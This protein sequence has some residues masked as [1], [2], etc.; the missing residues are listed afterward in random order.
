MVESSEI[1][2]FPILEVEK[3]SVFIY[4]TSAAQSNNIFHEL[5]NHVYSSGVAS[6]ENLL[7]RVNLKYS[8]R[9]HPSS[10]DDSKSLDELESTLKK[11]PLSYQEKKKVFDEMEE[12]I[13][14]KYEAVDSELRKILL[15]SE[16]H[17]HL[18]LSAIENVGGKDLLINPV[19]L[20]IYEYYKSNKSETKNRE[21]PRK[22]K[23]AFLNLDGYEPLFVNKL[24]KESKD[25]LFLSIVR[26]ALR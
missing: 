8:T 7:E 12:A 9:K 26:E 13:M 5:M 19:I 15:S 22:R 2:R 3:P 1:N 6:D 14:K 18:F 24:C 17:S 11:N 10:L 25:F 21:T 16:I 4:Q 20:A 23:I